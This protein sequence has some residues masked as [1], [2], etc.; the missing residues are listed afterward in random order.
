MHHCL[1]GMEAPGVNV[2]IYSPKQTIVNITSN[3]FCI[4]VMSKP[5]YHFVPMSDAWSL[6]DGTPRVLYYRFSS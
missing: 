6:D 4:E 5:C 1:R 2:L 3:Y